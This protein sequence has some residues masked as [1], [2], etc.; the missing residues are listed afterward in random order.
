MR[1]LVSSGDLRE[2]ERVLK[3][4]LWARIPCAVG[5]EKAN[6]HL[7]IWI[8]Q[9]SDFHRA[10]DIFLNRDKPRPVP[11]WAPLLEMGVSARKKQPES[12]AAQRA[13]EPQVVLLGSRGSTRTGTA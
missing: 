6:A 5:R 8:Q 10:L 12:S 1:L 7:G 4:L 11:C 2:L 9:E 13:K 3:R